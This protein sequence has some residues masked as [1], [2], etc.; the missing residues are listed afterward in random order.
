MPSRCRPS[1]R[2]EEFLFAKGYGAV[3]GTDE[4]GAGCWA[5]PVFAGAVILSGPIDSDLIRDSKTLSASQR[6]RAAALVRERALAWAVGFCTAGEIDEINIARASEMAMVRA[7]RALAVRPDFVLAD[8]RTL[9]DLGIPMRGIVGGD[10]KSQS[11]AAASVIAKTARD[12]LMAEIDARH[13]GYGFADHKGYGTKAH[14][15]ALLRLGPC[16]EHRLTYR[17]V[18]A[19]SVAF[20]SASGPQKN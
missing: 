11:I 8:F 9:P 16:P 7:V 6:E 15:E 18:A 4:A 2:A 12:A 5:G 1:F 13:P 20:G 14:R 10:G 17:P 19:C 3:A